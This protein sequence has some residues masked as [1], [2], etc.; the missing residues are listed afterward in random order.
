VSDLK[1]RGILESDP[2]RSFRI[3]E[4]AEEMEN[5][6][7]KQ[8]TEVELVKSQIRDL[9]QKIEM[10][11]VAA[12]MPSASNRSVTSSSARS[13]PLSGLRTGEL[14]PSG[15]A[16]LADNLGADADVVDDSEDDIFSYD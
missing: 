11:K 12:P 1:L 4:L 6:V 3:N 10:A 5:Q 8:Q 15:A 16:S 2:S 9:D 13:V 7:N 14:F